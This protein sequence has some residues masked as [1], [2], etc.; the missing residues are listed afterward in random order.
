VAPCT[1]AEEAD[2]INPCVPSAVRA[3]DKMAGS[4]RALLARRLNMR[5]ERGKIAGQRI[6]LAAWKKMRSHA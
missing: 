1:Q 5:P 4:C 3:F 6:K 2:T